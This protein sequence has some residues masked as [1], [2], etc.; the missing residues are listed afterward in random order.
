MGCDGPIF[1]QD[2][3]KSKASMVYIR[4]STV[5]PLSQKYRKGSICLTF[6]LLFSKIIYFWRGGS[7]HEPCLSCE[8]RTTVWGWFSPSVCMDFL[9]IT[10]WF[11]SLYCKHLYP[12]TIFLA[13]FKSHLLRRGGGVLRPGSLI[14]SVRFP[15]SILFPGIGGT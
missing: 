4:S 12:G 15:E 6:P 7:A 1:Q 8:V 5:T 2:L 10:F 11:S 9:E 3:C 14:L 13:L